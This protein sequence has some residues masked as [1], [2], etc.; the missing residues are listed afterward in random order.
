ME[1]DI[2]RLG[3]D[4]EP[5]SADLNSQEIERRQ[6]LEIKSLVKAVSELNEFIL[7]NARAQADAFREQSQQA[8]KNAKNLPKEDK[9]KE[10]SQ[11]RL[12][13]RM[14]RFH[15][16]EMSWNRIKYINNK[17]AGDAPKLITDYIKRPQKGYACSASIFADQA[18]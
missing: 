5:L 12:N 18:Q 4:K 1:L 13:V 16:V 7:L 15:T 8:L 6:Q 11:L 9:S 2:L 10:L 3:L 17:R 14:T